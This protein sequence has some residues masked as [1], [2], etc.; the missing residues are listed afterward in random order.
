MNAQCFVS[1]SYQALSPAAMFTCLFKVLT[2][3]FQC[4][5]KVLVFQSFHQP[6]MLGDDFILAAE[7]HFT[8]DVD[9]RPENTALH[10]PKMHQSFIAGHLHKEIVE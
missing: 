5:W 2:E 4:M 10:I 9:E 3:Q 8:R 7:R 1:F 6:D